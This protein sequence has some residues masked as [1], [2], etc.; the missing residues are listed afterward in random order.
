MI[1][2]KSNRTIKFT[3][4]VDELRAIFSHMLR[5]SRVQIA[6]NNLDNLQSIREEDRTSET[7]DP[8]DCLGSLV[9]EV[10]DSTIL[11]LL[12]VPTDHDT[13]RFLL[14]TLSSKDG[15]IPGVIVVLLSGTSLVEVILIKGHL[16]PT[17]VKILPVDLTLLDWSSTLLVL[18]LLD[19]CEILLLFV[20]PEGFDPIAPEMDTQEKDKNKTQNDKTKHRMEKIEKDQKRQSHSKPKVKVNP[21]NVKVKPDKAKAKNEENTI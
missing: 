12:L 20:L 7:V 18:L 13:F 6:E 2:P 10:L 8:Q 15:V 21:G 4:E 19:D 9:L 14:Y 16:F 3:D 17:T 1:I 5:A 11:T